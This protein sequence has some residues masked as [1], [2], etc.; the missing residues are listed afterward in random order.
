MFAA[1]QP[2]IKLSLLSLMLEAHASE[3]LSSL[4]EGGKSKSMQLVLGRGKGEG[5]RGQEHATYFEKSE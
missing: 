2:P 3:L 4:W 1:V 5:G